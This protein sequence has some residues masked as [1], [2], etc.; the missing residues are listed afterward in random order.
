[1]KKENTYINVWNT[2]IDEITNY[3]SEDEFNVWIKKIDYSDSKKN[4]LILAAPSQFHIAQIKRRFQKTMDTIIA[5]NSSEPITIEYV[6]SE[7]LGN[8]STEGDKGKKNY[9]TSGSQSTE[10]KKQSAQESVDVLSSKAKS[11]VKRPTKTFAETKRDYTEINARYTF[12][13]FVVGEN[14]QFAVGAAMS[15]AQN[16]GKT[17]NPCLIYG[18]VGLGKTHLLASI[19]NYVLEHDSSKRVA[20][21]TAENFT[22]E[23]IQSLHDKKEGKFKNK[24]RSADVLLI[25]DIHFLQNKPSTQEELFHTFNALYESGRQLVF[26]CDR[27]VSELKDLTD[28][29]RSRFTRGLNVD[30]QPPTYETRLAILQ[31]M[32]ESSKLNVEDE[33][34]QYIAESVCSNVRDLESSFE[35]LKAYGNLINNNITLDIAR[36]RLQGFFG[37]TKEIHVDINTIQRIVADYYKVTPSDIRGKKRTKSIANARQIAMYIA[38]EITDYA[39]TEIGSEFGGKMH[40]T[41]S[42]AAKKVSDKIQDDPNLDVLIQKLIRSI[43]DYS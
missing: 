7:H 21:V 40:T 30:L 12:E 13:K 6:V 9:V 10:Q 43:K 35:T 24:Y 36:E 17:H 11:G 22:N 37:H 19:G 25:D 41:V 3:I 29:L 4:T 15:I 20:F 5:E 26:T 38:T 27:P 8:E 23:F 32:A 42:H 16:P 34:L 31:R 1:M 18:G 39:L 33:V 14:S 2:L 28:R